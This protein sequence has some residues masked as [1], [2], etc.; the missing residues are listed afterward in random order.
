M[1]QEGACAPLVQ[2]NLMLAACAATLIRLELGED[3]VYELDAGVDSALAACTGLQH[4]AFSPGPDVRG[5]SNDCWRLHTCCVCLC[6]CAAA[7][8]AQ[9]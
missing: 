4:L 1:Q 8:C 2:V 9:V 3:A 5:P 7:A 6:L